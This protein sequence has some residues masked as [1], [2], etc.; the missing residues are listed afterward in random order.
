MDIDAKKLDTAILYLQ[1]IADGNNPIN[2][3]PAEEDSVLNNPNVIRCMYFVKEVLEEVKRNDGFVGR[4][5]KKSEKAE[6]P[7]E[8]L[9]SFTYQE[10]KPITRFVEQINSAI[11][12]N[13]FQ[14]ISYKPIQDWLKLN[15][16]L[17]EKVFEEFGKSFNVP[18]EK[19]QQLGIRYEMRKSMRGVNYIATVYGKNAQEYLV[20]NLVKIIAG[21]VAD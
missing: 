12:E 6:F 19:G 13:R 7:M 11:D 1:R 15:E 18:T 14:K 4:K 5:P 3:M 17:E 21:E 2:N 8:S 20:K 10:D 16:F 9:E